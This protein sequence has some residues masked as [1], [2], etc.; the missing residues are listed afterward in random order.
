MEML[1]LVLQVYAGDMAEKSV[2]LSNNILRVKLKENNIQ[3][4]LE[5]LS[6]A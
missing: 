6:Y 3:L 2:S 1:S 5:T 4:L